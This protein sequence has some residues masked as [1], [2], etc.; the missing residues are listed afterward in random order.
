MINAG[1][2]ILS[3]IETRNE[4]HACM[5]FSLP[6][7]E[8]VPSLHS[9]WIR[10]T[11]RR[12]APISARRVRDTW[13]V[14][15]SD[16]RRFPLSSG[17]F[18]HSSNPVF[19]IFGFFYLPLGSRVQEPI[20]PESAIGALTDHQTCGILYIERPC[21]TVTD[22]KPRLRATGLCRVR[23]GPSPRFRDS[24]RTRWGPR[25]SERAPRPK[26]ITE[27]HF[28]PQFSASPALLTAGP[29]QNPRRIRTS[30]WS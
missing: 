12:T 13:G 9:A 14:R 25:G 3:S 20:A 24:A 18:G 28:V 27:C 30:R 19:R 6:L 17:Q 16:P 11:P 29:A 26:V 1:G 8:I 23:P 10:E 15:R 7:P 4:I 5:D 2:R 21:V 22:R